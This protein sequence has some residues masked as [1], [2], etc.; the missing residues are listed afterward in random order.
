MFVVEHQQ[1]ELLLDGLAGGLLSDDLALQELGLALQLKEIHLFGVQF[2]L[3]VGFGALVIF[4]HSFSLLDQHFVDLYVPGK[5][6]LIFL[7]LFPEVVALF[8]AIFVFLMGLSNLKLPV[9]DV[10]P[11]F[12]YLFL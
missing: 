4:D 12:F 6:V 11:Q 1:V 10:L 5:L 8:I 9:F 7:V 2:L 3:Q